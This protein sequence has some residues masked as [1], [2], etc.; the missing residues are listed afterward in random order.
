MRH[1]TLLIL[2]SAFTTGAHAGVYK[3]TENG[4]TF[5]SDKPCASKEVRETG[6][7]DDKPVLSIGAQN[8]A[9]NASGGT[10]TSTSNV[11]LPGPIDFGQEPVERLN[12]AM[13][14][15]NSVQS[16]GQNCDAALKS[17]PNDA[18]TTVLCKNFIAQLRD[19]A[20][21]PQAVDQIKE[22][23]KDSRLVEDNYDAFKQSRVINE[24]INAL[25]KTAKLG[26]HES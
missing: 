1:L 19:G 20:Q 12:K 18:R 25:W 6:R 24:N 9:A 15:L 11:P 21:W 23:V 3:C 4:Q 13:A 10:H 14:I 17:A 5:F 26:L 7:M 2:L 22:L 16:D 8:G